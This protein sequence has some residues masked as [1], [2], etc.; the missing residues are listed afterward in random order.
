MGTEGG[1]WVQLA[2]FCEKVIQ[3]KEDVLT[4][5]RVIDQINIQRI[6]PDPPKEMPPAAYP[7]FLVVALKPG[8]ARGRSQI[9]L[10]FE[11]PSGIS[12]AGPEQAVLFE[13][14]HRG[15]NL[16]WQLQMQLEQEGVQWVSVWCDD[17]LLTRMP[18]RVLYQPTKLPPP[19]R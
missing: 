9:R 1:P 18:L 13:A 16:V 5:V 8:S 15:V 3:D 14:E 2:C 6:E 11:S 10:G 17:Q 4:L 7:L 12:S 19:P